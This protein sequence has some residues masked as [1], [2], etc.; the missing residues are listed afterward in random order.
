MT[1]AFTVLKADHT[2]VEA[3]LTRLTGG[4]G[5]AS[6][7]SPDPAQDAETL[8]M[9]ESRHEAA[10]EMYFWPTV[11][12]RVADGDALADEARAQ[13]AEGKRVLDEL[14]TCAPGDGRFEE[15]VATFAAAGRAH[16]DFEE[17]Q[18][19]PKLRAVLTPADAD[20][21]GDELTRA[22]AAG[23]TR[24]HP[25]A[26]DS[27]GALKTTGVAAAAMDKVRDAVSGRG[28]H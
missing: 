6:A 11:R 27:P 3:L 2:E 1:D 16:I 18:V 20:K 14:R 23:P 24:P 9:A 8:V 7:A 26:P 21:L 5:P 25:D 15:L 10:E 22:K 12:E 19:W 17:T 28:R 4:A 13:E